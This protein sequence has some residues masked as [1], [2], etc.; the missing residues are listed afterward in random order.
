MNFEKCH[1]PE[2]SFV[3]IFPLKLLTHF[4][5]QN[6]GNQMMSIVSCAKFDVIRDSPAD[7][8]GEGIQLFLVDLNEFCALASRSETQSSVIGGLQRY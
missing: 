2:V 7:I 3:L 6:D 8:F 5:K 1:W 4:H